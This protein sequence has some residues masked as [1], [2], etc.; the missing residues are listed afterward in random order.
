VENKE[1]KIHLAPSAERDLENLAPDLA[2]QLVKDIKKYLQN[3]P[4]RFSKSRLK[5]LTAFS[6]P[7]FRLRSGDYRA[8]FRITKEI[9]VI[10][11]ITY[12]KDS[13]KIFKLFR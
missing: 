10:L 3:R 9:V 12:K 8:Y 13:E 7:L 4:F 11:A 2:L 6:P 1:V 5:K